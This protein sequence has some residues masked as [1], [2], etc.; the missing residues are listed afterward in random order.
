M[1]LQPKDQVLLEQAYKSI[2]EGG[3]PPTAGAASRAGATG[4]VQPTA[5]AMSKSDA[6]EWSE[7]PDPHGEIARIKVITNK[8]ME[9]IDDL[10]EKLTNLYGGKDYELPPEID[11]L[12]DAIDQRLQ[13]I[14]PNED[15]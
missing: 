11:Q 14:V 1:K 6:L 4:G 7:N 5:P 12:F 8:V 2:Q 13:K 15:F 3:M 9:L 10:K